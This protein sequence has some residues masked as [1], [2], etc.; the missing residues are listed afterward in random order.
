MP[1]FL[2]NQFEDDF[3]SIVIQTKN[4]FFRLHKVSKPTNAQNLRALFYICESGVAF[5][6]YFDKAANRDDFLNQLIHPLITAT[7]EL[8]SQIEGTMRIDDLSKDRYQ[9]D[10]LVAYYRSHGLDIDAS[11]R[12]NGILAFDGLYNTIGLE[13][14]EDMFDCEEGPIGILGTTSFITSDNVIGEDVDKLN[15]LYE[16]FVFTQLLDRLIALAFEKYSN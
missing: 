14:L 2:K 9:V 5:L 12:I 10:R 6:S 16:P 4:D 8:A 13:V 15:A 1:N 7:G 11:Q 3:A